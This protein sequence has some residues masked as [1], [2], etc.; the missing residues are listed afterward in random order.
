M[1]ITIEGIEGA[2][3]TTLAEALAEKLRDVGHTVVVTA[4]PGGGPVGDS[5]RKILLDPA[6]SI[7]SR[8]EL[9]LF[10]AARAQHVETVIRSALESGATVICD[11][12]ID[13]SIAYQGAARGIGV[14]MVETLND[15]ATGG[16]KPDL[17]I[18]LDLPASEG[19][20]RQTKVDRVSAESLVFHEAVRQ[21][22]LNAA[23]REPER[24]IVIDASQSFEEVVA[25]AEKA[26]LSKWRTN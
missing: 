6:N 26:I 18:L 14:E 19:L 17:T 24:F 3:K 20:K 13:S 16:L 23:A 25:H 21:G 4:E 22:F 9:L 10:E 12:Y 11:R 5:I 2:G 7:V 15:F 8:A 1:F